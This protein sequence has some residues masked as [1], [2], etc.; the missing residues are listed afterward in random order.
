MMIN[1][2]MVQFASIMSMSIITVVA[3]DYKNDAIDV[4]DVNDVMD[5][6]K[7]GLEFQHN[8]QDEHKNTFWHRL[9]FESARC[10]YWSDAQKKIRIFKD[11]NKGWLPN[12]WIENKDGRT[13]HKEGKIIFNATGNPITKMLITVLKLQELDYLEQVMHKESRDKMIYAQQMG[14]AN[15]KS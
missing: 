13:A 2:R 14:L 5:I 6:R 15:P 4:N 12:P 1:V 10:G 7:F 8:Q 11:D 3:M 9:V